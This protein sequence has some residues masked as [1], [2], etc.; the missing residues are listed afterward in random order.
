MKMNTIG[1][2]D[3]RHILIAEYVR[4][5][6]KLL[7]LPADR[8]VAGWSH[9]GITTAG[10]ILADIRRGIHDRINR[11]LPW[12]HRDFDRMRIRRKLDKQVRR[13]R[14]TCQCRWCGQALPRYEHQENRFCE[15]SCRRAHRG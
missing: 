14:L 12:P 3:G 5:W 4:S 8:W 10:E 6:R 13:G 2:P 9:F 15:I 1:L 7:T 11:H